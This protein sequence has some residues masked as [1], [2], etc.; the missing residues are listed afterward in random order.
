MRELELTGF[1]ITLPW[2]YRALFS[3]WRVCFRI[4]CIVAASTSLHFVA[5]AIEVRQMS[6]ESDSFSS[7]ISS[8]IPVARLFGILSLLHRQ[9]LCDGLHTEGIKK[10]KINYNPTINNNLRQGHFIIQ[11]S[12]M[13]S[14]R[15][16][17]LYLQSKVGFEM[18]FFESPR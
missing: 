16:T 11:Y 3:I 7:F 10:K 18:S 14:W 2:L 13:L 15:S 4:R 1:Y 8:S 9:L 6:I 12:K 5:T 17:L